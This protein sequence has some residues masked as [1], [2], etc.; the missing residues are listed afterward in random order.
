MTQKLARK[1][2][3]QGRK[4]EGEGNRDGD[5]GEDAA[6]AV[7]LIAGRIY[8]A[9]LETKASGA[10][11]PLDGTVESRLHML[12]HSDPSTSP[13]G[14]L[15]WLLPLT[16]ALAIHAGTLRGSFVLDD[17]LESRSAG[18][19]AVNLDPRHVFFSSYLMPG[20]IDPGYR[21]L[22]FLTF[23][24]ELKLGGGAW[25][26]HLAN[27]L[28][29]AGVAVAAYFLLRE[30]LA[31]A[32]LAALGAALYA[33]LPI[34]TD[35]V[36][37]ISGR[38]EI[39]SGLAVLAAGLLALKNAPRRDERGDRHENREHPG[40]VLAATAVVFLG[41]FAKENGALGVPLLVLLTCWLTRRRVPWLTVAGC[42]SAG[43]GQL[44]IRAVILEDR[45]GLITFAENPLRDAEF[46]ARASSG[47]GLI[48]LYI[49]KT[50]L[51]LRL[52]AEYAAFDLPAFATGGSTAWVGA[53]IVLAVLG[54]AVQA[55]RKRA[56]LVAL[57]VV[58]FVVPVLPFANVF[59]L[60]R[61]A[62]AERVAYLAALAWPLALCATAKVAPLVQKRRG[63]LSMLWILLALLGAGSIARNE[64][65]VSAS[66]SR[67]T[68]A[69]PE[70]ARR[71]FLALSAREEKAV[72]PL[73]KKDLRDRLTVEAKRRLEANPEDGWAEALLGHVLH[74][75]GKHAEA[76]EHL[77]KAEALLA[78]S[79]PPVSEPVVYQLRGDSHLI[80]NQTAEAY[81]DIDRHIR[82]VEGAGKRSDAMAYSRRGLTRARTGKLDEA[83]LDFNTAIALRQDIPE[84]WNNR[85]FCRFK[86]GDSDGA[87]QDYKQ[88]ALLCQE[89]GLMYAVAGDSVNAFLLRIAD[90][91][92]S[93]ARAQVA[94]ND[95][96]AARASEAEA[97]KYRA[98][99]E[100]LMPKKAAGKE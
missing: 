6:A 10:G 32:P 58:F 22:T 27:V 96:D 5:A 63:V 53:V 89:Q 51:P 95:A 82:L 66:P 12:P 72:S 67:L 46:L 79:N 70:R 50:I 34:V 61:N 19:E 68:P 45:A 25:H 56:P 97:L 84:L 38:A 59:F 64:D 33:A 4:E 47:C 57:A 30:I 87:I 26:F 8:E 76:I 21:P 71:M 35:A 98:E 39:L 49:L 90:V 40:I 62:F 55:F 52:S 83:L 17:A 94:A 20:R 42:A 3:A 73:E 78:K 1:A 99:A 11:R 15:W 85:G 60:A 2:R 24:L 44:V 14:R 31:D 65:W 18:A 41:L 13:P 81:A 36:A 7:S 23:A 77:T 37:R 43:L 91:Y 100:R 74:R 93:A 80:L 54:F 28:L 92:V 69:S 29:H 86:L 75:Q 16:A 88:G 48:G 9:S